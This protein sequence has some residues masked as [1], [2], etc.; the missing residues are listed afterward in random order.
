VRGRLITFEGID[1]CGKSTQLH[2]LAQRLQGLGF[3]VRCF[4]EPGG[5]ELSER[6]RALLLDAA[7]E[8][9]AEAELL[10]FA[11]AR[12][13]L[14]RVQLQPA[15]RRGE[16]VLCDRFAD[17]TTAYQ[18]Y[19]RG[20]PLELVQACNRLATD[21][22][23]PDVTVLLE[24][25]VALAL[26][27]SGRGD[28]MEQGRWSSSNAFGRATWSWRAR[29]RSASLSSTLRAA[30]KPCTSG[31]GGSSVRASGGSSNGDNRRAKL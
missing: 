10:L 12:A 16:I 27:R 7:Y 20:L 23:Q 18:G 28:R 19:G 9:V 13:Q 5:T 26:Q 8:I 3:P 15:L 31:F 14:V 24:L 22:L 1:G 25:P 21:G 4:R 2:L 17:S 6:I 30:P 11:A 29:N